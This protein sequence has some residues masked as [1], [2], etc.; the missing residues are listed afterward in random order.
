MCKATELKHYELKTIAEQES[1]KEPNFLIF[2]YSFNIFVSVLVFQK[3]FN[4]QFAVL[5][6]FGALCLLKSLKRV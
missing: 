3:Q 5:N 4:V 1:E 6:A 2:E